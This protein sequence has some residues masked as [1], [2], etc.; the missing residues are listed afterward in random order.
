MLV[1]DAPCCALVT[2]RMPRL[3]PKYDQLAAF[4]AQQSGPEVTCTFAEIETILGAP[5][6]RLAH[7]RGWWMSMAP[8]RRDA[9]ARGRLGAG[10]RVVEVRL[11]STERYL[12]PAEK[13]VTFRCVS[14]SEDTG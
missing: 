6:P 1:S 10:W 13:T 2:R 12:L 7:T 14:A 8:S 11:R 9:H 4:L 5:L 3:G